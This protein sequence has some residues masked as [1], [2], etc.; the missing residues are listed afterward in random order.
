M[1]DRLLGP[2]GQIAAQH[3]LSPEAQDALI[4]LFLSLQGETIGLVGS[5]L[6][7]EETASD[8]GEGDPIR[9]PEGGVGV[10]EGADSTQSWVHTAVEETETAVA[11]RR[12]EAP[13]RY[14]D[15]G[16]IGQGGMG[17]VRRAL[18]RA[19]NRRVAI[20]AMRGELMQNPT[21]L[22][23]FTDEA[24]VVAQL[25]HPGV[26]PVHELGWLPD[27]RPYFTMPEVR[28]RTLSHVLREYRAL[29]GQDGRKAE[30]SLRRLIDM[31]H[32]VCE[33]VAYAHS[34]GVVHRDL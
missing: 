16:L 18:D 2:L 29:V 11:H 6:V 23:R 30:L 26:V 7:S 25:Q 20:K 13:E 5:I 10:R 14:E 27:G 32:A 12:K 4:E 15:Q 8:S 22:R 9:R 21:L 28:G 17:E 33:T 19:L 31:F 34:R 3:G 1:I 24:Q